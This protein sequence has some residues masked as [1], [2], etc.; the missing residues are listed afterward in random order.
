MNTILLFAGCTAVNVILS[1]IKS[2]VTVKGGKLS[3]SLINALTYGFYS[4]VIILTSADGMSVWAKMGITALC[5][6]VGVYLVKW[7]EEKARKDKL[8]EIRATIPANNTQ[9]V[10][11]A[12]KDVPHN[13]ILNVGK[14]TVFNIY[15]ATQKE[16]AL[17]KPILNQYGAKYFVSESK[18]LD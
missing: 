3:A 1:T 18:N 13:Y 9:E 2:I 15:C 6:F 14:Y 16:S 12:L 7:I 5:N 17:V 4:Y 10:H 8:W 11:S